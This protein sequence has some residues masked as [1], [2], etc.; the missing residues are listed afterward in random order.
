MTKPT[1][2]TTNA[3]TNADTTADTTRP[4]TAKTVGTRPGPDVDYVDYSGEMRIHRNP[5]LRWA[6]VV[7]G[8]LAIALG[9]LGYVLPGLPGTVFFLIAAWFFAQSSPRFYNWLMNH[10]LFGPLIRDYRA[11]KGI[12]LWVKVY[13]PIMIVLF[14]SASAA[15]LGWVRG[16][17]WIAVLVLLVAAYGVVYVLRV[18]TK[19]RTPRPV[20]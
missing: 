19:N 20:E 1:P 6:Y 4:G 5:A 17:A 2:A 8:L 13:A 14:S 10:R 12:P 3:T 9:T 15:Y 11:G 7:A 16:K 18:P